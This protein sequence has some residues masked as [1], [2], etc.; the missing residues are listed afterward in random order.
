M[1]KKDELSKNLVVVS[2]LIY[3]KHQLNKQEALG[4]LQH[5]MDM[6]INLLYF[7]TLIN[8]Y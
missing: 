2:Y 6:K 1:E 5:L 4:L 7:I 8:V 3:L